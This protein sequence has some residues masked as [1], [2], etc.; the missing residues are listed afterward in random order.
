M[1]KN[2]HLFMS[3]STQSVKP[4]AQHYE[5][6]VQKWDNLYEDVNQHFKD[7]NSFVFVDGPPYANGD[8]HLGHA[9]NKVCKDTVVK[10]RWYLGQAAKWTPG[11][12]CHG[13]PLELQVDKLY[14]TASQ[15]EK[16]NHCEQLAMS[17]VEKQ[18]QSFKAL[19]CH[20]DWKNP[21]L[22]CQPEMKN[23]SLQTLFKMYQKDLLQYKMWPVHHCA[24]CGSSLA[25]AELEYE[26]KQRMQLYFKYPLSNGQYALVW[27]T[28]AW[29][30]PMN[31]ALAFNEHF[32][33]NQWSNNTETL[34]VESNCDNEVQALLQNKGYSQTQV[35][36]KGNYF[37]T[38]TG[39]APL[40]KNTTTPLW[41]ADFVEAGKTG[42]VHVSCAHG[43]E[44]YEL[45]QHHGVEP[46]HLLDKYGKFL[47][48]D[49]LDTRL[50]G[51]KNFSSLNTVATLLEEQN[52]LVHSAL[53]MFEMATCWR[54][55]TPVYY[56]STWQVFLNLEKLKPQVKSLL[57][58]DVFLSQ[59]VKSRLQ[60]MLLSRPHWC[61]S[62]QRYWGTSMQLLVD[63]N[64]HQL[65]AK[66]HEY[67]PLVL[68]SETEKA[69]QFLEKNPDVFAL[70]DVLDVWFDSGN[71]V[72][73]LGKLQHFDKAD[74]VV[75]GKDQYRGWFQSLLWLSVAADNKLPYKKVLVHGFV[76]DA[77][78]EKF[79]KSKKNGVS[80]KQAVDK[81][82]PDVLRLWALLQEEEVDAVFSEQK[83]LEV[84]NLYQRFRLSLR[85]LSSN[86]YNATPEEHNE[87]LQQLTHKPEFD[88]YN[89]VLQQL[90]QFT[91][92]F[93]RSMHDFTF[94]QAV[95]SLYEF[96]DKFLSQWV[97]E[98]LKQPL[99]LYPRGHL[100]KD[101]AQAV[102]YELTLALTKCL[103]VFT[104]FVAQEFYEV[105]DNN[106]VFT[107]KHNTL[108]LNEPKLFWQQAHNLRKQV[109]HALEPMQKNKTVKS[110]SQVKVLLS[111]P[112]V[113]LYENLCASFSPKF[114]LGTQHTEFHQNDKFQVV[115]KPLEN[116]EK[117]LRCWNFFSHLHNSVCKE[118]EKYC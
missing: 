44:D 99:Y 76:L 103:S 113:Q 35:T 68:A 27:T 86:A 89:Y 112:D 57:D 107:A 31:Q 23:Q 77:N 96:C 102:C 109:H 116:H 110:V 105:L 51:V 38:L 88:F 48:T 59:K 98:C 74:M 83:L 16:K 62:R 32:V 39:Q 63:K 36:V 30:V 20:A 108:L 13:L 2:F 85:F 56:H 19:G 52:L 87:K 66:N 91:Q 37:S 8:A 60:D 46:F 95:Y 10:S 14:P 67:M 3:Q 42:F 29:T 72:Q 58:N 71:V 81:Y 106:C 7:Q 93:E 53:E 69:Q 43:P 50:H 47:P 5:Q 75:E 61:L 1:S 22:T 70:D 40:F 82:N 45:G 84:Q 25:E 15:Q 114:W 28:T 90:K 49:G 104:P 73:A 100:Q 101:M 54:H 34:W 6:Q 26:P 111:H 94:K 21:Y 115:L 65:S 80:A 97:F 117:C 12:D 55:K 33:Y 24:A 64:T 11:W 79:S 9:L 17:S 4:E 41:H 78:K 18:M 118:C 92:L